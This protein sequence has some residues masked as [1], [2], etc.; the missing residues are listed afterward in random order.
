MSD[1]DKVVI[2]D[3]SKYC[4]DGCGCGCPEVKLDL[5]TNTVTISDPSKPENGKF[6]MTVAE[7]NLLIKNAKSV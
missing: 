1:K 5:D 2:Y 3:G 4:E 6:T 7:Y